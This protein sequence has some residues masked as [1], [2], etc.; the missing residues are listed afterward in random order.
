M[1]GKKARDTVSGYEGVVIGVEKH[2]HNCDRVYIQKQK[3]QD[4]GEP[5]KGS[6]CD[7]PQVLI[8][9]KSSIPVTPPQPLTFSLGDEVQDTLSD[10]KGVVVCVVQWIQGC[11]RLA[12]Q[13]REMEKGVP[14]DEISLPS[15]QCKLIK[16]AKP[17]S[18][19]EGAPVKVETRPGGPMKDPKRQADPKR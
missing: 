17:V 13:S 1:L 16:S 14:V 4:N 7:L 6:W 10:F 11:W 19:A 12:I 3:V 15:S 8:G 18:S 5:V 9:G 2:L